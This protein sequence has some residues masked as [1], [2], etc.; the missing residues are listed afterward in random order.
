MV[1]IK[2]SNCEEI[3]HRLATTVGFAKPKQ[4]VGIA[5]APAAPRIEKR[6][7][8]VPPKSEGLTW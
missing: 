8:A 4:V 6:R 1:P 7:R 2:L 5:Q 3:L